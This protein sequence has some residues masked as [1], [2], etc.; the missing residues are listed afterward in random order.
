MH[1]D[2]RHDRDDILSGETASKPGFVRLNLSYLMDEN[3]ID[4]ILNAV[5]ALTEDAQAVAA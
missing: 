4:Y 3:T 1:K 2:E 5:I